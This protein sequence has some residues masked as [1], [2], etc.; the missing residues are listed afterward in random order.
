LWHRLSGI[1]CWQFDTR[2]TYANSGP[3]PGPE[4]DFTGPG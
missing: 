4:A 2:V 3:S 1:N